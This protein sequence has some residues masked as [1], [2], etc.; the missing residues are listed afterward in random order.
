MP[1][2]TKNPKV[3][4]APTDKIYNQPGKTIKEYPKKSGNYQK[5]GP[6]AL[7]TNNTT[8]VQTS[9]AKELSGWHGKT[10]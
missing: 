3:G 5:P 6:N 9:R 1:S 7:K 4:K 8:G 10:K 2:L